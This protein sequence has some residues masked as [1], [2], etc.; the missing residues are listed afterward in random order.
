M[1]RS[2]YPSLSW[3]AHKSSSFQILFQALPTTPCCCKQLAPCHPVAAQLHHQ[4][5]SCVLLL[6]ILFSVSKPLATCHKPSLSVATLGA[7]SVAAFQCEAVF[8]FYS[9]YFVLHR[10]EN[11]IFL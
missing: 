7:L 6:F 10:V 2:L 4:H 11:A 1:T 8:H 9:F 5:F 3:E